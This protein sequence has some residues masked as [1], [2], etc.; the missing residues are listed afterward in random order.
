MVRILIACLALLFVSDAYSAVLANAYDDVPFVPVQPKPG[1][2]RHP[3]QM[4]K[5]RKLCEKSDGEACAFYGDAIY[6]TALEGGLT[7]KMS[8]Q[9]VA[10]MTAKGYQFKEQGCLLGH[11][12]TCSALG[13]GF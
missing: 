10:S 6:V 2:Y 1:E 12:Y 13:Y 7:N 9:E 5:N 11:A 8:A 4:E 3:D